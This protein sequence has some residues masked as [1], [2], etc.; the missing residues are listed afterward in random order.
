[1]LLNNMYILKTI[2]ISFSCLMNTA[3]VCT[4]HYVLSSV[5][6]MINSCK[7]AVAIITQVPVE[8]SKQSSGRN[9]NSGSE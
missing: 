8:L 6:N 5:N 7:H 9:N 1:M 2:E 4:E 3:A